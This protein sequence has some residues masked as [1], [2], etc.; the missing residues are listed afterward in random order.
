MTQGMVRT[1][2]A[3][4]FIEKQSGER[5]RIRCTLV[6]GDSASESKHQRTIFGQDDVDYVFYV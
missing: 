1:R 6:C 2:E 5:V 4:Y 3:I